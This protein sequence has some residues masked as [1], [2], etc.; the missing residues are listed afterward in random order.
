MKII[1]ARLKK[2]K[3]KVKTIGTALDM[4]TLLAA[5]C[6]DFAE[7][8]STEKNVSIEQAEDIVFDSV[9]S[10]MKTVKYF[11]KDKL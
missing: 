8:I 1:F 2:H 7:K 3:V 5:I 11:S 6:K 4:L 9:K 10:G